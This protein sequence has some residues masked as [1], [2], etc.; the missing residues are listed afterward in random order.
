[1][2]WRISD[3]TEPGGWKISALRGDMGA[4]E[5]SDYGPTWYSGIAPLSPARTLLSYDLDVDVCVIGGGVAG[6]TAGREVA[7]CGWSVAV[8]EARRVAWNASGRNS[9]L[10]S[11]GY[12]AQI[13][14]I[15]ERIGLPA[16]KALWELSEAGVQYVDDTIEAIGGRG[17]VEGKGS[18]DVFKTPAAGR[19]TARLRLLEQ[20]MGVAVH[21]LRTG[22]GHAWRTTH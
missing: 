13:E 18:L 11:P 22:A 21:G 17:I 7:R 1:M 5:Q 12:S 16:A 6:L 20:E 19:A 4:E 8:V 10:V 2:E 15:V 9:G 3:T 14:K